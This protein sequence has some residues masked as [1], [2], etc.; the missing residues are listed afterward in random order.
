[1][2]PTLKQLRIFQEVA[3]RG[4]YTRAA[5]ALHLSQ[6]AV[7]IQVKQLEGQA[8]LP[9]FEQLGKKIYLTAAG[10]EMLGYTR[11]V[12]G[13]LEEAD[14]V[15][16]ALRGLDQ[17]QLKVSVATTAGSFATRMLGEFSKRHPKVAIN[18]D[19]TNREALVQQLANNECDLV[20][21]GTPPSDR[22][23]ES[24]P[25]MDNPLVVITAPNHPLA[26]NTAIPL[27]ELAKERF[28]VRE[29][30]SGTRA[31]IERFFDQHQ[32]P[33]HYAMEMTS[34]ES[35]KQ[36]VQAGLGPG[37]VSLHTME[38]EQRSNCLVVLDVE[39]FPIMRRW[40]VVHH[41]GKRL[42]PVAQ[43]FRHL[44]L[45][46]AQHFVGQPGGRRHADIRGYAV[47]TE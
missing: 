41:S 12:L 25:F 38:L 30:G 3:R 20:I 24:E 46:E 31:A 1:M 34:S 9:L 43:S 10:E 7:S 11:R 4:S 22:P 44:V 5:E 19:V 37:I 35:I 26:G 13:L 18:L 40:Y 16:N 27:S 42:S 6:P 2:N 8:G 17:G 23:L 32:V 15:M 28:V 14:G 47:H 21:M 45:E 36:A 33:F 39:G 29:P